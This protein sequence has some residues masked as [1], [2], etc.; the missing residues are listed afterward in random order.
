VTDEREL[1]REDLGEDWGLSKYRCAAGSSFLHH[2]SSVLN[3]LASLKLALVIIVALLAGVMIS[4]LSAVRT[5]WAL[6]VP[7]ALLAVNLSAAVVTNASFWRQKGLLIFHLALIAIVLL[8]AIERLT[9]LRGTLELT[10]G[11]MFDGNLTTTE[12]GPLH[13]WRLKDVRFVQ[14]GFEIDY[15]PGTPNLGTVFLRTNDSGLRTQDSVLTPQSTVP[16]PGPK[17][18][19]ATGAR[20]GETHNQVHWLDDKE[21]WHAEV[22]GDSYPLEI[23]GYHFFTTANKGY[24]PLFV[25]T[26]AGG[27]PITGSIHLPSYPLNEFKQYLEWTPPGSNLKLWTQ[28]QFDEVIIDPYKTSQFRLPEQ[29]KIVIRQG[30][31]RYEL[32]PGG[33]VSLPG[34]VL[35]Y[36]ELSTWM[37]YNVDND[38]TIG[39]LFAACGVAMASLAWHFWQKFAARPWQTD[40]EKT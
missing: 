29:H 8:I 3:R 6:V 7:L 33:Q 21:V 14:D 30:N 18:S 26:P 40:E 34:G 22:I 2:L 9:Y 31:D 11:V 16:G 32:Q 19:D 4:Y 23:L 17:F 39:W 25:W 24:A 1:K 13:R 20:R 36:Q 10:K 37:G 15:A 27:A 38:W 12:A 35:A 28:L 5:T